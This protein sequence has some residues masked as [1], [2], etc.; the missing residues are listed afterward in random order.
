MT[1]AAISRRLPSPR[2]VK[3]HRSDSVEEAA[4]LLGGHKN[5]VREW[6][7]RGLPLVDQRRPAL[8]LGRELA[9]FLKQRRRANK[10]P[11]LPGQIYCVRCRKPQ[12]PAGGMADFQALTLSTGNLIGLCPACDGLMYRRVSIGRFEQVRGDLDVRLPQAPQH[13]DESA[14]P[15]VNCDFKRE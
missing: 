4:G 10:R 3:L 5:T 8:I 1:A 2:L 7:R 11:C 14:K 12:S 6:I 15:S 13:I 9:A